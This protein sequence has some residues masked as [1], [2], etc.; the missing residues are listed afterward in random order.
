MMNKI[1][2]A[3]NSGTDPSHAMSSTSFMHKNLGVN[4]SAFNYSFAADRS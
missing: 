4:A 1:M 3:L 2:N